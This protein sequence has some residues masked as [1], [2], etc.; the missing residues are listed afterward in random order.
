MVEHGQGALGAIDDLHTV[1][2]RGA[3]DDDGAPGRS[4]DR[5]RGGTGRA[6]GSI[7]ERR[8]VG[9]TFNVVRVG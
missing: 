1:G 6:A 5:S 3:R 4:A 8:V 2:A 9:T 7:R